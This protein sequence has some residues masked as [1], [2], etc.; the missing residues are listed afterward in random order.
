[1]R[2]ARLHARGEGLF[3]EGV[4]PG[5]GQRQGGGLVVGGGRGDDRGVDAGLDQLL[6]AAQDG[7]V[8]GDAEA[9][10]ARVCE[11]D[12]VHSGG[13]AGVAHVVPAHRADAEDPEANAHVRPPLGRAC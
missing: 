4:H 11:G 1:M 8:A 5:L 10:A 12:E 7:Q 2:A 3:D 6:D 9:V 13:G